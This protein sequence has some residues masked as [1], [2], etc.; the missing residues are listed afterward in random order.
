M[1]VGD[2]LNG[3]EEC[4]IVQELFAELEEN[5]AQELFDESLR[6]Q[7]DWNILAHQ[8]VGAELSR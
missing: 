1:T 7:E 2:F 8:V 6:R 5:A 4:P 3:A